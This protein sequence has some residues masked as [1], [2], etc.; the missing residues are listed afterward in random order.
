VCQHS[1]K[2]RKEREPTDGAQ[3]KLNIYEHIYISID[4]QINSIGKHN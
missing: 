3:D 2:K 1:L 4:K